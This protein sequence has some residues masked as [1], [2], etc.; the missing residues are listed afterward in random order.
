MST[1]P[2]TGTT[3]LFC[4]CLEGIFD[5]VVG[6]EAYFTHEAINS[7]AVETCFHLGEDCLDWIELR[8]VSNVEHWFD[9]HSWINC[10]DR[11]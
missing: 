4:Y 6:V 3:V 1:L 2:H 7:L 9:V 8:A 5:F 10:F 11:L